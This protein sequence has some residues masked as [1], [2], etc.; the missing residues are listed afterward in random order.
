MT[1]SSSNG[2]GT[3]V[4]TVMKDP[5]GAG[6]AIVATGISCS[7][8]NGASTCSSGA[9]QSFS[10]TD[11]INISVHRTDGANATEDVTSWTLGA[12]AIPTGPSGATGPTGNTGPT[13][14]TGPSG[15]SGPTGTTGPTGPSG[16]PALLAGGIIAAET[17]GGNAFGAFGSFNATTTSEVA[18]QIPAPVAGNLG[19]VSVKLSVAPGAGNSWTVNLRV[20]GANNGSCTISDTATTCTITPTTAAVS[21]GA[22]VNMNFNGTSGPSATNAAY[23]VTLTP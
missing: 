21:I 1:L 7:I 16:G 18:R 9:S 8:A 6:T 23:S 19:T 14:P 15:P 3:L 17:N 5:G 2:G 4:F 13:G 22:L 10:A 12:T 11:R 20:N